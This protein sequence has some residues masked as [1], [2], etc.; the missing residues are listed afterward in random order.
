MKGSLEERFWAKVQPEP[1]SGC[2]LW[3]GTGN[4]HGYSQISS[5][6]HSSRMLLAHRVAYELFVGPIPDHLELDHTCRVRSCV[7][8]AH[9]EPVTR[10]ENMRRSPFRLH[11]TEVAA[12]RLLARTT[13]RRGHPWAEE[14][15]GHQYD[16]QRSEY[17][18]Y[19][20]ICDRAANRRSAALRA[21]VK[22]PDNETIG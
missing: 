9:L 16:K 17:R 15:T 8:P 12:R 22:R 7:N 3:L 2:Y 5:G 4:Q 10:S 19:C 20:L 21:V 14:T 11:A 13:C 1:M 18:R 6:G